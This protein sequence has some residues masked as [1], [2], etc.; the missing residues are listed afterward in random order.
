VSHSSF[1]LISLASIGITRQ[2]RGQR[3]LTRRLAETASDSP[4]Q[5]AAKKGPPPHWV[6]LHTAADSAELAQNLSAAIAKVSAELPVRK[7]QV[8][9]FRR[10]GEAVEQVDSWNL[11]VW[12]PPKT[13][14]LVSSLIAEAHPDV[15]APLF[16]ENIEDGVEAGD[17][18]YIL[19]SFSNGDLEALSVLAHEVVR[20]KFAPSVELDVNGGKLQFVTTAAGKQALEA[21]LPGANYVIEDFSWS[22]IG[23]SPD[24]FERVQ[25]DVV[26]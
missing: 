13:L 1:V 21:W 6:H 9:S 2:R 25:S 17:A 12:I 20:K 8:T 4:A 24:Y 18:A 7:A 10:D 3:G 22:P 16:A 26:S 5:P 14:L 11:S 19:A 23:G 15:D